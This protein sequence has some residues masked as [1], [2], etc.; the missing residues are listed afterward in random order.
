MKN[1]LFCILLLFFPLF[2]LAQPSPQGILVNQK[3]PD[4]IAKDQFGKSIKLSTELLKGAVVIVFYRGQWCPY[5]NRQ[6]KRLEDSLIYIKNKGASLIAITPEKPENISKT[7]EKTKA[8]YS[9][10]YDEGLKIM[11]LYDVAFAVDNNTVERY[12]KFGI[13]LTEVNGS[14]G[15]NLPVPALFVINQSGKIVFRH[16]DPDYKNRVSVKEIVSHL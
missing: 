13:D 8:S 3:A 5:C 16:F 6:L 14:N 2:S 12:K 1:R 4:F 9:V 15:A 11:K 10:L 7:I